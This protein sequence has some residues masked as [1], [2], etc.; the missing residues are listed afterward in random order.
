MLVEGEGE[1]EDPMEMNY[2]GDHG[3]QGEPE[4]EYASNQDPNP[5]MCEED[6]DEEDDDQV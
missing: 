3:D 4:E 5:E 2:P 6:E 1:E